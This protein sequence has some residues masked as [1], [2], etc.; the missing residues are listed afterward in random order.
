ML[1]QCPLVH[2]WPSF[3]ISF[4]P[5]SLKSYDQMREPKLNIE[6]Y[7]R[8][9]CHARRRAIACIRDKIYWLIF[10]E[11][12]LEILIFHLFRY[13]WTILNFFR[14]LLNGCD[15]NHVRICHHDGHRAQL[16]LS[17][18]YPHACAR[19]GS[20]VS[21]KNFLRKKI[22]KISLSLSLFKTHFGQENSSSSRSQVSKREKIQKLF[23]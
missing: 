9:Y 2:N 1:I 16:L 11:K 21:L 12:S 23:G 8:F 15:G 3:S 17:R 5:F 14:G 7:F 13:L 4:H 19:L 6:S 18:T 22:I 20:N 10:L